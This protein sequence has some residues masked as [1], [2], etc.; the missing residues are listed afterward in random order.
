MHCAILGSIFALFTSQAR[1]QLEAK[2]HITVQKWI[3]GG[4]LKG[5]TA[6]SEGI[7][8]IHRRFGELLPEDLLGVEGLNARERVRVVPGE[9]RKR[10]VKVGTH[11]AVSPGVLPRFLSRFEEVYDHPKRTDSILG[12][13]TAHHRRQRTSCAADVTRHAAGVSGYGMCLVG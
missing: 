12:A 5:R 4:G 6:S 3:D 1:L 13:A 11:I 10:D 9:L 7:R 8:E 2:A